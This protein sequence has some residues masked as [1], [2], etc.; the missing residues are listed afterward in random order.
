MTSSHCGV[1]IQDNLFMNLKKASKACLTVPPPSPRWAGGW[2]LRLTVWSRAWQRV[3]LPFWSFQWR[4]SLLKLVMTMEEVTSGGKWHPT[5][6]APVNWSG[7][8]AVS[9]LVMMIIM[10]MMI[11]IFVSLITWL[12]WWW[13]WWLLCQVSLSHL[14]YPAQSTFLRSHAE[15]IPIRNLMLKISPLK[16]IF[17]FSHE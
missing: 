15:N 14:C 9:I 1:E 3:W 5:M 8:L 13:W 7:H 4:W 2:R 16:D 10:R 6:L 17:W 11:A 12:Q